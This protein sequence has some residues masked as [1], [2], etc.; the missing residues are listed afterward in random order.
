MTMNPVA[1][2]VLMMATS[3]SALPPMPPMQRSLDGG[4]ML[5]ELFLGPLYQAVPVTQPPSLHDKHHDAPNHH[6]EEGVWRGLLIP[7]IP[8]LFTFDFRVASFRVFLRRARPRST[9]GLQRAQV[10]AAAAGVRVSPC[11][12]G[13]GT[14]P[15]TWRGSTAWPCPT[16]GYSTSGEPGQ[17]DT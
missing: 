9:A 13:G 4:R 14:L 3:V 10:R 12:P 2:L 16:A 8:H 15:A 6:Y 1:R 17:C 7:K 5:E 11:C